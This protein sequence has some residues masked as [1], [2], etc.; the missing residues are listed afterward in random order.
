MLLNHSARIVFALG[1]IASTLFSYTSLVEA[2]DVAPTQDQLKQEIAIRD[3]E[4]SSLKAQLTEYQ[5][6][7]EIALRD[8]EISNLKAQLTEYQLKQEIAIKDTE[9]ANL[10]API[11]SDFYDKYKEFKKKEYD[12]YIRIMDLNLETFQ[13]QRPQTYAIM[14]L[15]ILVV[16]A[17]I[18]FSA[19][20]LWRSVGVAGVQLNSEM[21]MSA[22]NVRVTSSVVG[23]VVLI[24]SIAFLYIYAREVY[25]LQTIDPFKP[26]ISEAK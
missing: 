17:G 12:Y 10:K 13:T 21:E 23:I 9:I 15:V 3:A 25:Q 26:P 16:I 5:L 1:V 22:R 8:A 11:K 18:I 20:Q 6:K 7:Q 4:I 2:D 14:G 19:F 24:I